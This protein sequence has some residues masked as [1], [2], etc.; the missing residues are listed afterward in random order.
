MTAAELRAQQ[1][2][3][4]VMTVALRDVWGELSVPE[5]RCSRRRSTA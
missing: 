2:T 5:K 3:G 4:A 1:P